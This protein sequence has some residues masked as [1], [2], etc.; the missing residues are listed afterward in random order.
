[1]THAPDLAA[2]VRDFLATNEAG[3]QPNFGALRDA[4]AAFDALPL[5]G[6]EWVMVPRE[7]TRDMLNAAIDVD[8]FKLG[9]ISPLGFR[10]S[11]QQLFEKCYTAM[12]SAAPARPAVT[13]AMECHGLD[14]PTRIRFYERD[15]YPLSNFS[16]FH[17]SW[18]GIDFDTSEAAYHWAKFDPEICYLSTSARAAQTAIRLARSAHAAFKIAERERQFRRPDWDQV[19]VG[20]MREIIRAK[21]DQHKYVKRK[22]LATGERELVED[23]WRDDFWGWGP[24]RDGQNMLGKLWMELRAAIA[25]TDG[26]GT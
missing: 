1:M 25:H 13:E 17:V 4:L 15:F 7:P 9:D 12:I 10:C 16:A 14:T 24:N 26:D 2:T 22:L 8:S 11:P 21:A 23:S 3:A 5:Q 6:G 20:V 19:R 18:R